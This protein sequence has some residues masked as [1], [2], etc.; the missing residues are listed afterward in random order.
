[1]GYT[2]DLLPH[3]GQVLGKK[4]QF[5]AAGF[6]GHGMPIIFLLARK[7]KSAFPDSWNLKRDTSKLSHSTDMIGQ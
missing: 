3:L 2:S 1:M 5:I 6:N 4:G 7:K